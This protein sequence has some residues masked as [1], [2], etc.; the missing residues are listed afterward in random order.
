MLFKAT[1]ELIKVSKVLTR[2]FLLKN[3]L[4]LEVLS[5]KKLLVVGF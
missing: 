1:N 4:K 2:C 3:G 5:K